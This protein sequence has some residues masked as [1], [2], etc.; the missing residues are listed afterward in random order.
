MSEAV[1]LLTAPA[2]SDPRGWSR[3]SSTPES[4]STA[5]THWHRQ[6]TLAVHLA[7]EFVCFQEPEKGIFFKS[8]DDDKRRSYF[9]LT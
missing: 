4:E 5:G 3:D 7:N 6:D 1:P 9:K 2:P 8:D